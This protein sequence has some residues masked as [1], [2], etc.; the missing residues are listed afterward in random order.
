MA[1]VND[2]TQNP[3]DS[4]NTGAGGAGDKT[5]QTQTQNDG[6]RADTSRVATDTGGALK[7]GDQKTDKDG[8]VFTFKEDRTDWVPRTRLNDE[9]GKRTKLEQKVEELTKQ[10][11]LND[12]RLRLA[13]GLEVPSKDEQDLQEMREA[14]YKINP[15]LK[16]LDQLDEEQ[17]SRLL[18]AAD[19]ANSTTRAQWERHRHQMLSD[20]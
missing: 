19:S 8:K 3:T 11:E 4:G 20:L 6:S 14:L 12:K 15:K 18:E 7:D 13:M 10:Q 16:L 1:L 5:T 2:G 17:L 9:S